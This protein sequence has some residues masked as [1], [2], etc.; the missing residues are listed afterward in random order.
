MSA[1]SVLLLLLCGFIVGLPVGGR[2]LSSWFSDRTK[3]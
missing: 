3:S 1:G 2:Y